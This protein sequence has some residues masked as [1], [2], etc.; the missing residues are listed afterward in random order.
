MHSAQCNR[1]THLF[2]DQVHNPL[3]EGHRMDAL[4]KTYHRAICIP[5]DGIEQIWKDYDTFENTLNRITVIPFHFFLMFRWTCD[6][7]KCCKTSYK[8]LHGNTK[9]HIASF[10][11][12]HLASPSPPPLIDAHY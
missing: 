11:P 4:R 12:L 6:G 10:T 3:E 8:M 9:K 5:L 7:I 2:H 1:R